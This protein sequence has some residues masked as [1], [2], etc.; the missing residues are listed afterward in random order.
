LDKNQQPSIPKDVD[1]MK[2]KGKDR[3]TI[4]L[5]RLAQAHTRL[6]AAI[7]GLDETAMCTQ[8]VT[9]DWTV[10]DLLGHIVSWNREFRANIAAILRGEHPGYDHTISGEKDF[11]AWNQVWYLEKVDLPL[12]EILADVTAD[13]G[14]ARAL[15]E[16]LEPKDY[17]KRGVTPWKVRPGV[18]S[19]EPAKEDTDTVE[20][21][22]T[23]HWRHMNQHLREI[24]RWRRVGK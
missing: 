2:P 5:E 14:E 11:S 18:V 22:V 6:Q 24:E 16:G 4:Y 7:Q 20:T 19:G 15:I 8:A 1:D 21:L 10:K 3:K 17:R 23:F 13:Y 12:A 9:G